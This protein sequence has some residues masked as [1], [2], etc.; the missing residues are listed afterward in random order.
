[1]GN[2][3]KGKAEERKERVK[4]LT[5]YILHKHYC[6]NDVEAMIRL[7]DT[8]LLWIGAAEHEY[9]VG[10][11]KVSGIFRQF[12]GKV[13]RCNLSE[14]HYDV[15]EIAPDA[16]LCTG[17]V[18]VATDPS[19]KVYLRVHQRVTTAFRWKDGRPF[20]C[21]IHISN[22]YSEMVED[23]VG[24]PTK[25]ARQSYEYMQHCIEQQKKQIERQTAEL[26]SIYN[27]VPC[28]IV[29]LKRGETEYELLTFNRALAQMLGLTEDEVRQMDW[30]NGFCEQVDR[31]D[32]ARICECLSGLHRQGDYGSV[33]YRLRK[34]SGDVIY[35]ESA[36]T[37][38][39]M[40]ED[41]AVLQRIA[42][43]VTER[44]KMEE[45]LKQSSYEDS[46]TG[47]F[48]RNKFNHEMHIQDSAVLK[49][50][51]ILYLDL[52]GLKELNDSKGHAAGDELL[53]RTASHIK[54]V[55]P[56]KGYRIGG[57]EFVVIEDSLS[58][59]EF[60]KCADRLCQIMKEDHIS[61][62]MGISWRGSCC[63]IVRQFEEADKKMYQD[64][65]RHYKEKA[66]RN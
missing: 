5:S 10:T 15:I 18:W 28:A 39:S 12:A 62:A 48:N 30:G 38:I 22:P 1:M 58:Q 29:R 43:D 32:S 66:G 4:E 61:T 60:R 55:F 45:K 51:G 42:F 54:A 31:E 16:Y 26:V 9:D 33:S 14:E 64:K 6:E 24:F 13:P 44:V 40:D 56:G 34:P 53:C 19:T 36:N 59:E 50:L 27:T 20:C 35:L 3:A 46:L 65:A 21:H 49:R 11:Q 37:L 2:C 8:E 57:D 47:L 63:D 41:A 23:D 7:F 52:N 25:M 17:Q